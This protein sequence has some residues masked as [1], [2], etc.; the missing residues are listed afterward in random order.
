LVTVLSE[1]DNSNPYHNFIFMNVADKVRKLLNS[2]EREKAVK[3]LQAALPGDQEVQQI[4]EIFFAAKRQ[5]NKQFLTQDEFDKAVAKVVELIRDFIEQYDDGK[6]RLLYI[7][8]NPGQKAQLSFD[9]NAKAFKTAIAN[10]NFIDFISEPAMLR[11]EFFLKLNEYKPN[12]LHLSMH[13]DEDKGV[14]FRKQN[15][16][17]DNM[18]PEELEKHLRI[19][20]EQLNVPLEC[21]VLNCCNSSEHANRLAGVVPFVVGMEGVLPAPV[22]DKFTNV[23]YSVLIPEKNYKPCFN[24]AVHVLSTSD[25]LKQYASVPKLFTK[26]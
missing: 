19:S 5:Y 4:S 15:G 1:S 23:F 25:D 21:V 6:T 3:E 16:Q 13:G 8:S 20:L 22:A 24:A 7:F 17:E 12:I 2:G 9:T 10:K 26:N 11:E 18:L 14:Y